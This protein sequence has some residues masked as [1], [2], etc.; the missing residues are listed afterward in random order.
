VTGAAITTDVNANNPQ[1]QEPDPLGRDLSQPLPN[2]P[3]NPLGSA[4]LKD[5]AMPIEATWWNQNRE[6]KTGVRLAILRF[7]GL[8]NSPDWILPTTLLTAL[9]RKR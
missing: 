9:K 6:T 1:R 2:T 7:S 4:N 5:R 8:D 3:V